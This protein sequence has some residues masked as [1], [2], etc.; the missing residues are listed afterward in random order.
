MKKDLV[1][2]NF[3][4]GNNVKDITLSISP[5][6]FLVGPDERKKNAILDA[7]E[8]ELGY[9][10]TYFCSNRIDDGCWTIDNI[11]TDFAKKWISK[12]EVVEDSTKR[13]YQLLIILL[14]IDCAIKEKSVG[15][16]IED[17][18]CHLYPATQSLLAD[19]FYEAYNDYGIHFIVE[20]HSEYIVRKTQVIVRN[21]VAKEKYAT[22]EEF[23]GK[24]PFTTYYVPEKSMGELPYSLGYRRDGKFKRG[25]GEG[26]YDESTTLAFDLL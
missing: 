13:N 2:K 14:A 23:E 20:T 16:I 15:L 5:I 8:D 19:M 1:V 7:V 12:L 17:P 6:T 4:C 21:L 26:F 11:E 24:C 3:E 9:R 25:F 18:E 10:Y 22:K